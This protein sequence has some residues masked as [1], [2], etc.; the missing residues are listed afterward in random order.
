MDRQFR[1]LVF[2]V[3]SAVIS[4]GT[5]CEQAETTPAAPAL[6]PVVQTTG[7]L[8]AITVEGVSKASSAVEAARE[9]QSS[10]IADTARAHVTEI[11]GEKRYQK[12]KAVIENKI[13]KQSGKFIPFVNAGQPVSLPDG[14]WKM[15]VEIKLSLSSLRKMIID[16]GFMNEANGPSSLLPLVSFIDRRTGVSLRWWQGEQKDDAH[17][18]VQ[19]ISQQFHQRFQVEFSRQGFHVIKPLGLQVSPLPESYR[20]DRLS[21]A[22]L[23][24]VSEYYGAP[25]VLRGD[26]RFRE[27]K[28]SAG[29]LM[30][31]AQIAIKIEVLQAH[32]GRV[33][34]E[35]SRQF[36]ADNGAYEA[37]I[38][39]KIGADAGEI[40]KDLATQVFE[41]W[42]RGSL[43]SNLMR[44]LVRGQLTP[45]QLSELKSGL[46]QGVRE[47]KNLKERS[48]EAGQVE[49]EL[50]YIGE[51][52][53]F[54]ERLR[55]LQLAA[56]ATK[57][58]DSTE[59]GVVL[60]VKAQ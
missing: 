15:S 18:F 3:V 46:I 53:A 17:K 42:Q 51:R 58:S 30:S 57:L 26:V 21:G 5:Y 1:Q 14:T 56:F 59:T 8:L 25:M 7:D 55:G 16:N 44:L 41:A 54:E 45:R 60:E 48:F 38:R 13:I 32:S 27:A 23:I 37:A 43:N 34:A 9:V 50:D 28:D 29:R 49:F 20:A 39:S 12:S 24:F 40:A 6:N 36:D 4:L 11:I 35:V 31:V 10:V 2:V 22:D 47:L 33:V 52:R 19:Q